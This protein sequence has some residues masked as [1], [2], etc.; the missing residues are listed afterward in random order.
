VDDVSITGAGGFGSD[1][2]GTI[3]QHFKGTSAAAPHVA[4]IAAL[5]LQASPCL[6]ASAAGARAPADARSIMQKLLT[7]NAVDLGDPGADNIYGFGRV[8]ALAAVK[9]TIPTAAGAD[10]TVSG[11]S[12]NGASVTT[13]GSGSSDP[14]NCPLTFEWTGTC[15]NA[16]SANPTLACP[17]GQSTENLR[18]TNNGVTFSDTATVHI[19]VT[20]FSVTTSA[21]AL[22][23]NRGQSGQLTV[24]VS[25]QFGPF[26]NPI[27]LSCANLPSY[28]SC[29]FAPPTVTPG[30]TGATSTLTITAAT[31]TAQARPVLE[32]WMGVPAIALVGAGFRKRRNLRRSVVLPTFALAC[33]SALVLLQACGGSGR[34]NFQPTPTPTSNPVSATITVAAASNSLQRT[35]SV[36]VTVP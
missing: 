25:P 23:V 15:G 3:P 27:T 31:T 18:V 22:T 6:S 36:T 13:D 5:L 14:N 34:K 20:D 2:S 29:A 28:L 24:S 1:P 12:T 30:A 35:G 10:I 8:D 17:L 21:G 7:D 4:G 26:T 11:T 32:M 33:L 19:T 9:K 16:S